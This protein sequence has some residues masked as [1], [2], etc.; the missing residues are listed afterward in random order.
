MVP[1]CAFPSKIGNPVS[2]DPLTAASS[3]ASQPRLANIPQPAQ[4]ATQPLLPQQHILQPQQHIPQPQQQLQPQQP[5]T[6]MRYPAPQQ[7]RPVA[8]VQVGSED[9]TAQP[10]FPVRTLNPYQNKWVIKVRVTQKS[11][12]REWSNA[13]GQG[14]LF[15]ADLVDDEVFLIV[16][17]C[18]VTSKGWRDSYDWLSR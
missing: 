5:A 17:N 12:I 16:L 3:G 1:V 7:S 9:L 13:K 18:C 6:Q 15:S 11:D 2:I 4:P 8:P 10:I 14:K